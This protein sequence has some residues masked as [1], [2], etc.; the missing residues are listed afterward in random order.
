MKKWLLRRNKADIGKMAES[1]HISPVIAN[2]LANRG[3]GTYES[4]VKYLSC[5]E[6]MMYDG[7]L[8]KDMDKAVDLIMKAVDAGDKIAVYGDYDVDGVMSSVILYKTLK[9][10]GADVMYYVPHRQKE[11]YGMNISSI[12]ELKNAGVKVIFACDNG[13][14]AVEEAKAAENSGMTLIILDHHEPP[15]EFDGEEEKE[16]LPRAAAVVDH[17]RKDCPYPF[18][19]LCAGG[20]AFKFAKLFFEA[21]GEP[22]ILKD[23]L[24]GF[25]A[26]ATICD[27]VDLLDENRILAKN[28]LKCINESKN[29]GLC[30]LIDKAGIEKGAVTEYHVGFILG[31]CVNA[32]GRLESA[33]ESVEL[34]ITEDMRQAEKLA[35]R[36]VE[37]NSERKVLTA[38]A[39]QR[40]VDIIENTEIGKDNV[41]VI[42]D[43]EIHE[44]IAGIVAGRIKEKYYKPTVVITKGEDMAKGSARSIEGYNMFLELSKNKELFCRF[45]GHPMAAGLSLKKENIDILRRRLNLEF[46]LTKEDMIPSIHIEKALEF[47][48][49]NLK[50]AD[51]L[52]ELAPF[53]KANPSPVFGTKNV[54]AEKIRLVGKEKNIMQ[55]SFRDL[56]TGISIKGISFGGL[57]DFEKQC[58]EIY[59]REKT[60]RVL[61][62]LD[63]V[64]ADIIYSIG[65]NTY[66]GRSSVQLNISD[67]RL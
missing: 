27:I 50:L 13:I 59:G 38:R 36:L 66:L 52:A 65:V 2:I 67:F 64:K 46:S 33:G 62:G 20:M 39:A 8:F 51:E 11:G 43:E 57:E 16:I 22:F 37:L 44:S 34:F 56:K 47:S 63:G 6:D 55:I 49:I 35:Q 48:E 5:D 31:P 3:I 7:Y 17:K 41:I 18:K 29:P 10:F 25:A 12:G 54:F 9:H 32:T 23:E 30:A 1:L 19:A 61:E 53:G 42:Y 24:L 4:A 40:A 21:C 28:G 60:A 58:A 45:G 15:V 26:M 14:A